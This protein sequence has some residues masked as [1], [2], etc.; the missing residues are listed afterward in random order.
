MTQ[1]KHGLSI[2]IERISDDFFLTL[3]ASGKLTHE[4]YEV[5]TPMLD[6]AVAG[7]EHPHIK[8]IIDATELEGWEPQAAWDDFKLGLK[9]RSEFEKI[10]MIGH[11]KWQ[12]ISA[13]LASWF[14]SGE[15]EYFEDFDSA[16][17]WLNGD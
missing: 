15:V 7:I 16:I 13:K 8:A 12:H 11:K 10:A 17:N 6:K 1:Q 14:I 4:D 9:Y 2:G 5:I 3:K